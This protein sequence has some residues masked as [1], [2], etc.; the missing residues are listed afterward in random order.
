MDNEAS[1]E[2]KKVIKKQSKLQ[3][4]PPDLHRRNIAERAIQTFKNHFVAILS[5]VDAKFPMQLWCKLLP[6]SILTLNL[7]RQSNVAP[8]VSAYAYMHGEFSYND[9]PLAPLG[10][11]V[12]LYETPH[13]RR[14]WAKHSVDGYY[15]GIL[16]E[17]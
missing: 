2:F 15:I 3:M 17:H 6:Q 14:T 12:Q 8:K 10:C 16:D 5:G 11:T 4:V 9:M 13:W 1:A 7:M